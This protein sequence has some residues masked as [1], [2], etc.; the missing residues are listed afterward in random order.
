MGKALVP[1][2]TELDRER[3]AGTRYIVVAASLLVVPALVSAVLVL[4]HASTMHWLAVTAISI[5]LMALPASFQYLWHRRRYQAL[6]RTL[7]AESD[8]RRG[9][10][11][12]A[13]AR[14]RRWLAFSEGAT[15]N[16]VL[17]DHEMNVIHANPRALERIGLP[18]EQVLGRNLAELLPEVR[19][20]DNRYARYLEVLRTGVPQQIEHDIDHPRLG[21]RHLRVRIFPVLDGVGMIASD[22]TE[23]QEIER[24][25][26]ESRNLLQA[27]FDT[28]PHWV[29]VKDREARFIMVNRRY[30]EW[31]GLEPEDFVGHLYAELN[32]IADSPRLEESDHM[33]EQIALSDDM[34]RIAL[35]E[36]RL[37]RLEFHML[38]HA[39]NP[40]FRMVTK[41]PLRDDAGEVVGI[42]GISE[43]VTDRHQLEA[44]L[45]QSQKMEVVGNLAGGMAHDFNNALQIIQGFTELALES[46]GERNEIA[47]NLHRVLEAAKSA[48]AVIQQLL[49]FSRR[50][51]LERKLINL[52]KL[53]SDQMEM[54][55]RIIRQDIELIL[56][57][58]DRPTIVEGDQGL[59]AQVLVNLCVNARDAMADGGRITIRLSYLEPDAAFLRRHKWAKSTAYVLLQVSD[60]G[61]GIPLEAQE[62]IFEPFYTTKEVGKGTGLGLSTVYGILQQHDGMV[63]CES[64]PGKGTTFSL[65]LPGVADGTPEPDPAAPL[66]AQYG[67]PETILVAEDEM[68]LRDYVRSLLASN[69]YRVITANDGEQAVRLF[70]ARR[71]EI[72][73]VLLDM[74][75]PRMNGRRAYD[76]MRALR[77]QTPI[78]ISSGFAGDAEAGEFLHQV[79][80]LVLRK[81]YAADDLLRKVREVLDQSRAW[82]CG[83]TEK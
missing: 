48:S 8:R 72:D 6:H 68:A 10:E 78:L 37:N 28:V 29:F 50:Q 20:A 46:A 25:L 7:Q 9:A 2:L 70:Q 47:V 39:G 61:T 11:A 5:A 40:M 49:A 76:K 14:E 79:R 17:Y 1:R 52:N 31:F 56:E 38:D 30:S 63:T 15:Q 77:P 32:S 81:P 23:Q 4:Q 59:L 43:D 83:P 64:T 51:V 69:G 27:V 75:M 16:I 57:V 35:Q 34:D 18:R 3:P 60:T 26:R 71:E 73:L 36:G 42:V 13:L 65:Y 67:G 54:L 53:V 55:R 12:D 62:H 41:M 58:A 45:R 22:A 66:A 33:R 19:I 24:Q 82:S 74:I 21:R 44:Q 80:H